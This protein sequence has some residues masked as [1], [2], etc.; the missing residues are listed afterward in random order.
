VQSE[1]HQ[2]GVQQFIDNCKG[3]FESK[4]LKNMPEKMLCQAGMT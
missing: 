1:N 3:K 2:K 4:K